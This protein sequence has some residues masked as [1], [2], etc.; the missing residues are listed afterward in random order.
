MMKFLE[1]HFDD[2]ISSNNKCSLHPKM[3][4]L[5]DVFPSKI[6][7]FKNDKMDKPFYVILVNQYPLKI[8]NFIAFRFFP[9]AYHFQVLISFLD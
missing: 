1:T 4:K 8:L 7:N 5:Y 9:S 2:Y 6:E 3:N